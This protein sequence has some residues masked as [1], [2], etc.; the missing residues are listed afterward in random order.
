[1]DY[2]KLENKVLKILLSNAKKRRIDHLLSAAKLSKKLAKEFGVNPKDAY[3]AGLA[4][5]ISKVYREDEWVDLA[6]KS[7]YKIF[8]EEWN[9]PILLHGFASA[10]ILREEFNCSS[11]SILDAVAYHINGDKKLSTLS[12][13]VFVSDFIE[14]TREHLPKGFKKSLKGKSIDDY[15]LAVVEL[16][17]EYLKKRKDSCT[18]RLERFYNE[19]KGK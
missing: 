3:I 14:P 16:M 2:T 7:G 10:T 19:L 11:K 15:C 17:M 9:N 1:M 8:N 6:K 4:H 12:K 13:I 5:D 18:K